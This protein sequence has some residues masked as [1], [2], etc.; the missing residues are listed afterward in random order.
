[1]YY[2]RLNCASHSTRSLCVAGLAAVVNGAVTMGAGR[3]SPGTQ[4]TDALF[5][6]TAAT[7][8]ASEGG[9]LFHMGA[10][11]LLRRKEGLTLCSFRTVIVS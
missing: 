2:G 10:S 4:S 5:F 8:G 7:H 11:S 3:S 1:M 9:M 6:G